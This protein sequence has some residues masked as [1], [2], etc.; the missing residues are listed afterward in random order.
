MRKVLSIL[1]L[2]MNNSAP[3]CQ[4]RLIVTDT[5]YTVKIKS[6][7]EKLVLIMLTV[8]MLRPKHLQERCW[9][10]ATSWLGI[11]HVVKRSM[12]KLHWIFFYFLPKDKKLLRSTK[13]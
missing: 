10:T 2:P 8:V 5:I 11:F 3:I 4:A 9:H 7:E 12:R 13:S 6:L 1:M